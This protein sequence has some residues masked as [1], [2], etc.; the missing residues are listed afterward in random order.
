MNDH[1]RQEMPQ[2][3]TPD[4]P[5]VEAEHIDAEHAHSADRAATPEEAAAAERGMEEAGGDPKQ[6][7]EH[8]QEMSDI[9]AHVKGEGEVK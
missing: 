8:Y 4:E 9:G 6:V 3:T 7:A 1:R 2:P 5:T